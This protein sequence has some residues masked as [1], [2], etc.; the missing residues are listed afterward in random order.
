MVEMTAQPPEPEAPPARPVDVGT[1]FGLWCTALPV[2]VAGQAVDTVLGPDRPHAAVV[3]AMTGVFL[4]VLAAIVLTFLLLMWQRYR[5]AR[6]LL[7]GGGVATVVYVGTSL[8]TIQRPAVAAV[9]YAATAIIG[10]VLIAGGV[11]LLHRKDAHA[12]F[13]R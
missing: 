6:T 8:F 10:S 3:Y 2:L 13:T 11:Y 4:F 12:Y 5:W 9:I 1:G 7:T